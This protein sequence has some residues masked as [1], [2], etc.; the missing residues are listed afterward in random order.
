MD[1]ALGK[2]GDERGEG[3]VTLTTTMDLDFEPTD[4][5]IVGARVF[6][7]LVFEGRCHTPT[8]G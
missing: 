6:V 4:C 7:C 3:Q 8:K 2:D 5:D 1:Q